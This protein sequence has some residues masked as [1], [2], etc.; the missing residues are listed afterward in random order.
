MNSGNVSKNENLKQIKSKVD[1]R[2]LKCDYFMINL[3]DI[4]KK[5]KTLKIVKFNKKLQKRLNINI[6]NYKEYS[7]LYSLIEIELKLDGNK[8]DE[9]NWF[10]YDKEK[11][12]YH[13]YF[14]NSNEEIEKNNSKTQQNSS[15]IKTIFELSIIKPRNNITS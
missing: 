13:I 12:Y 10:I 4:M 15:P 8:Y 5:N 9:K 1:F 3:F 11:E 6:N 2:K 14:D 7:Q